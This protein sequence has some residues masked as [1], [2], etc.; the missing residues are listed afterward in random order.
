MRESINDITV[1]ILTLNEEIHIRRCIESAKKY[2]NDIYV[3]DSFSTDK[4]I[5]IAK[6]F[7]VNI[8][9]NQFINYS[10]QF[11]WALD[12]IEFKT[13]WILR[14][15]ADEYLEEDLISEIKTKLPK[16]KKEISGINFLIKTIFMNKWI[17]YGG[18]YPL[19][20]LRLWKNGFGKI[21]DRWMDEHMII[22]NGTMTTFKNN[23]CNHN[24]KSLSFFINKHDWYAGREALDI[25]IKDRHKNFSHLKNSSFKTRFKRFLKERFY[26]KLA[27]GLRSFLY[28]IFRYF[29]L[30]GFLDGKIGF[31]YHFLQ[32]FWYRFLVDCK[33]YEFKNIIKDTKDRNEIIKQ[34]SNFINQK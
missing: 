11:A 9:Q 4:T 15:D 1:I 7:N 19:I 5:E 12:N 33:L 2:S 8:L 13:K 32:G 20:N 31:I 6:S 14:L 28:F 25:I 34:L 21:E 3:I 30:L 10:K 18:R 26:N 17:K 16:L 23:M 24:L 29:F 22:E 27:I